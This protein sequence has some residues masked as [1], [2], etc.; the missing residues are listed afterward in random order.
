MP[1]NNQSVETIPCD[2]PRDM[3]VSAGYIKDK[4]TIARAVK[5]V[6]LS[7]P[8]CLNISDSDYAESILQT[9]L[10][11]PISQKDQGYYSMTLPSPMPIYHENSK[12]KAQMNFTG[13]VVTERYQVIPEGTYHGRFYLKLCNPNIRL[14]ASGVITNDFGESDIVVIGLEDLVMVG[15][16]EEIKLE[17]RRSFLGWR[18]LYNRLNGF[19]N[20]FNTLGSA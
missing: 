20:K 18:R 17:P 7:I 6:A 14:D 11:S 9:L 10:A 2:F 12:Y 16:I 4:D 19:V 5:H 3:P 15:P 13:G 1:D 8:R